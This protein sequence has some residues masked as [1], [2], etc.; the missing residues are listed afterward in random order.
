[1]STI[2]FVEVSQEY[3]VTKPY[4][5]GHIVTIFDGAL[6]YTSRIA[7][8]VGESPFTNP[9]KW[10]PLNNILTGMV[11]G[12]KLTIN[13]NTQLFDRP[14]SRIA[15]AEFALNGKPTL[16]PVDIPS[17]DGI[18][19]PLI[20]TD[21][22]AFHSVTKDKVYD[23]VDV[24][25]L[26]PDYLSTHV[27]LGQLEHNGGV[28]IADTEIFLTV[29]PATI[30]KAFLDFILTKGGIKKNIVIGGVS[31]V[32]SLSLTSNNGRVFEY[33]GK[34]G[35]TPG[36]NN[37]LEVDDIPVMTVHPIAQN[38]PFNDVGTVFV[39]PTIVDVGGVRTVYSGGGSQ[40]TN[41]RII[42]FGITAFMEYA[43][44][45]SIYGSVTLA[46]AAVSS[47]IFIRNAGSITGLLFAVMSIIK[48]ALNTLDTNDALYQQSNE[49]GSVR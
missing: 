13:A 40:A 19:D 39:D 22:S 24:A 23:V 30:L 16:I 4:S 20:A 48:N 9:E 6:Q 46:H 28:E 38:D 33:T 49:A 31:G 17:L 25:K 15:F 10:L 32:L 43:F 42:G 27:I 8:A 18:A 2:P 1:M 44:G 36:N 45:Q 26:T 11:T 34:Q 47:E 21:A 12:N 37:V 35:G 3:D 29:F 5:V 41:P 14:A 7:A